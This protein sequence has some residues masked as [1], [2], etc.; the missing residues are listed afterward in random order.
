[1]QSDGVNMALDT[2]FVDLSIA[3]R[4]E[5]AQAWRGVEYARA[6]R[7]LRPDTHS[8]VEPVAGGYAIYAGEGSPLNRAIGLGLR[9]PVSGA[10]LECVEQF[11][12]SRSALPRVDLC[13]LA[14]PSLL[15]LLNRGGYRLE[16][17]YSVLACPLS[18]NAMPVSL[19]A[20]VRVGQARPEEAE[21]WIHTTAQGFEEGEVP[22][23]GAL[24]IL[25]P[26]FHSANA[27]CFFAWVAGQPA[28]GGAL[29][30]HAGVAELGGASTR[31]AFR[32]RSVHTALLYA[33]LA[34]AKAAACDLALVVTSPG[35][36]SQRNVERLGFRL[37]YTKATLAGR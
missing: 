11:Y 22:T 30:T 33:R 17:F 1:L 5:I 12:L 14:D 25:A 21:L 8:T 23:A 32:K 4:L 26:N 2:L 37:A 20:E 7:T 9:G 19:P 27:T 10:D 34:A 35:A 3:R 29:F 15:D 18:D 31:L 36:E 6:Q 16:E 24:A 13:P 28:G